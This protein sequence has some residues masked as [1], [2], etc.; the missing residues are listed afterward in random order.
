[1]VKVVFHDGS[2]FK[3]DSIK[4]IGSFIIAMER[5]H[6]DVFIPAEKVK[7]FHE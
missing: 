6:E 7:E 5:G 1:M 3:C 2:V 4:D